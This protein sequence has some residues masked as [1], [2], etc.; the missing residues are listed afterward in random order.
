[1][2]KLAVIILLLLNLIIIAALCMAYLAVYISP[3]RNWIFPFFGLA[4]PYLVIL[5]L[6]FL[7][8]WL[9][10]KPKLAL[11]PLAFF[12]SGYFQLANY[13]RVS[14]KSNP[15]KG[16]R[17]VSY[18]VKYFMGNGNV[19]DKAAAE[20]ILNYLKQ[21]KAD[22]ICLQEVQL[23]KRQIFDILNAKDQLPQIEHLQLAHASH[24]GGSVTLTTYPIINMNELRFENTGNLV[25]YTDILINSDTVRVYNCHL[26][27]Y[28]LK[29]SEINSID[30]ITY[31]NQS[32]KIQKIKS[33]KNRLYPS[34]VKRAD[35]AEKLQLAIAESPYPVIVCGDFNDT[36]VS[37]VYHTVRG[38]LL[39]AFVQS[40]KGTGNT[41]NGKLPSFRIDY[42]LHSPI[43]S[44]ANFKTGHYNYSDHFPVSCDLYRNPR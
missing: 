30:S 31:D 40:G 39:D 21:S 33:L 5:N 14:G 18:N 27:S 3:A 32:K 19:P 34:L 24:A 8:I 23:N 22:I 37:Y 1:M 6:A 25:I 10:F 2:K 11:L 28:R 4:F 16:I 44:A 7:I 29:P 15:E 9:V 20:Q 12:L 41:Y 17:I 42:I 36:P 13:I 38:K 43:F 35:Q 26:E